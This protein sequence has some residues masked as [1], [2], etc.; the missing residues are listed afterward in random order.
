MSA[1]RSRLLVAGVATGTALAMTVLPAA[2]QEPRQVRPSATTIATGLDNPRGLDF[3]QDGV[4]Y[5]AE[6]GRGG[7]GP[8]LAGPEGGRVC[9]GATGAITKISKGK[10][11]RVVRGLPSLG[12][13]GDGT[14]ATG[15]SDVS[16][17]R[18]LHFT[19]G[20][21]ADP[22]RRAD[23]P[24]LGRDAMGRL[25]TTH[26]R[27]GWRQ[28]A[29]IAGYEARVNPDGGVRD[30][31]PNSVLATR[32]GQYVVDAGGNS[33]LFVP[34]KGTVR[35]VATF[36]TRMVAPPPGVPAPPGGTI[37]M[38]SV[39]TSV[40]RGPDGALYVGELT[41]FPFPRGAA[42]VYRVEPG[43]RPQVYAAGSPTSSTSASAPVA[44]C[45]CWRSRTTGWPRAIRQARCS[46]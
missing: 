4:L 41:G 10:R 7:S 8:C 38:Q 26:G 43:E 42:R 31:N 5:V 44:G 22:A 36:P 12:D 6:S 3:G 34:R 32:H 29:D 46:G 25:L 1:R 19:V 18:G 23:L 28:Q 45:T 2:G 15:P 17:A 27:A 14:S 37:P 35:T 39:P 24:R 13:E 11:S 9:F 21:G 33:L 40:V 30:S 20:L 16:M